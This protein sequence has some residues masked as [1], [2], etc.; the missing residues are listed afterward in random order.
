[1]V[2]PG[3]D[4][5]QAAEIAERMRVAVH[6]GKQAKFTSALRISASFGVATDDTGTLTVGVLVD[7][8]DKALYQAKQSGRNRVVRFSELDALPSQAAT[9]NRADTA[10]PAPAAESAD[11]ELPAAPVAEPG[12]EPVGDATRLQ[13]RVRELEGMLES[14]NK[15]RRAG[16]DDATGLPN[17]V[18]LVDRIRQGLERSRRL[19]TQLAILVI[20]IDTLQV[21][22]NT[23]GDAAAEK[24]V[25]IAS[26]RLRKT[27]RATDTIAV[28]H[29]SDL[30]VSVSRIGGSE[31]AVVLT[32]IKQPESTTWV[33]Q[34]ILTEMQHTVELEGDEVLLDSRIGV[35]LYPSD[36]DSPEVLLAHANTALREAKADQGRNAC[37]YYGQEMNRR[38]EEQL[39]MEGQLH[40]AIERG[41]LFLAYQ[42]LVDMRS[43][44]VAGFEALLRWQHGELGMVPP[45]QFIDVAEHAGLIDEIGDW[46]LNQALQQLAQWRTA[47]HDALTMS[48]NLSPIQ[49]RNPDLA[50]RIVQII[51]ETGVA[52][53]SL[54]VEITESALIQNIDNAVAVV[55]RLHDAG[56]HI[57]LDDFG[58]GY[59]SLSY[60]KR[61]PIDMVK[62]DRSFL[63]D[64]PVDIHDT[65]IVNA[66]I[67]M[68][69]SLGLRVVA[70]GVETD[71]QLQVLQ[72]LNC[73]AIQGYLFSRPISREHATALLASPADI[74]RRVRAVT[75]NGLVVGAPAD[76]ALAGVLNEAR[77][78]SAAV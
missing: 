53:D 40:R 78:R 36:G 43:G 24:L 67:A 29:T 52:A 70:E 21:I 47:G 58:T 65:A 34:R 22:R 16:V 51:A 61:F 42:P 9:G 8:A 32:D 1:V 41:E 38:S 45:Q 15:D 25:K 60:L 46:V 66:V 11:G 7:F 49:F 50:E 35:S 5:L 48:I 54:V 23:H 64:F 59:S 4:E 19:R 44:R 10:A 13:A 68:A 26:A 14:L 62:I 63:R 31:F 37:L 27:L 39:R 6:D 75:E 28:P 12:H 56:V 18:V 72:N 30:G 2:L 71:Q 69:H 77:T 76:S 74:R 3:V 33:V 17:R 20:D 57:A 73:D 55:E